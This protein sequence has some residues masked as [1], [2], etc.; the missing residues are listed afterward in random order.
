[1][2][3]HALLFI[4]RVEKSRHVIAKSEATWQSHSQMLRIHRKP[5]RKRKKFR[6]IV[7]EPQATKCPWG[8]TAETA[9]QFTK[10]VL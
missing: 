9:S 6:E 7:P 10:L 3:K 8:A 4:E 1:M 2:K 5:M